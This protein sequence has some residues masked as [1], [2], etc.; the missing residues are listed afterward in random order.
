MLVQ[1]HKNAKTPFMRAYLASAH[2]TF[3]KKKKEK[4]RKKV[5]INP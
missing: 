4:R 2:Q 5:T 1:G 3:K